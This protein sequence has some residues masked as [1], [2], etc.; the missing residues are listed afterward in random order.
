M[1]PDHARIKLH[2]LKAADSLDKRAN[3]LLMEK[4]ARHPLGDSFRQAATPKSNDR[5]PAGH[6]FNGNNSKI[7][8]SRKYQSAAARKVMAQHRERLLSKHRDDRSGKRAQFGKL[9]AA[10]DDDQ[11]AAKCVASFDGEFRPFVGNEFARQK[12]II[13]DFRCWNALKVVNGNGGMD[14]GRVAPVIFFYPGGHGLRVR[15]EMVN[16][17]GCRGVPSANVM[18]ERRHQ[19]PPQPARPAAVVM[20][21]VPDVAHWRVAIADVNCVGWGNDPFGWS[22]FAAYNEVIAAQIELLERERHQG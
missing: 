5:P 19:K 12:I 17:H 7:F 16:A 11:S 2:Q 9:L 8:L 14:N 1:G 21:H 20:K 4:Q 6:G 13:L 10:A 18:T 22:R 3:S 15:D